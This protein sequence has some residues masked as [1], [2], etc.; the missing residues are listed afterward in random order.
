[1]VW[2]VQGNRPVRR[3]DMPDVPPTTQS[4]ST[5]RHRVA[6][7]LLGAVDADVAETAS[8]LTSELV[9]NAVLHARTPLHVSVELS[10][11]WLRVEVSDRS[12]ERPVPME[13]EEGSGDGYGLV[14]LDRLAD[15]WGTANVDAGKI[16]WFELQVADRPGG[17]DRRAGPVGS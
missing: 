3:L 6:Q 12:A 13:P 7:W 8:L 4:V 10:S 16:V 17:G 1:M 15:D 5:V 11:E 2:D 14:L 9:S